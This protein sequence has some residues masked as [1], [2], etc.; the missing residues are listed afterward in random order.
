MHNKACRFALPQYNTSALLKVSHSI[1]VL[2]VP[3]NCGIA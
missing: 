3:H 2:L 1:L